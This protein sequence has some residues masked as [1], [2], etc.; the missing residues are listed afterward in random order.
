ML[1]GRL[2]TWL[3][4]R[5]PLQTPT[6]RA[7][8]AS[9]P[10]FACYNGATVTRT[11]D[12]AGRIYEGFCGRPTNGYNGG[13]FGFY[14]VCDGAP[15]AL[16]EFCDARGSIASDPLDGL[17]YW[18]AWKGSERRMNVVPGCVPIGAGDNSNAGSSA[19]WP[20]P[21][22]VGV[23]SPEQRLQLLGGAAPLC[24]ID[25]RGWVYY[26]ERAA[27]RDVAGSAAMRVVQYPPGSVAGTEVPLA[28]YPNDSGSL[29]Q[30]AN[31]LYLIGHHKVG[32]VVYTVSVPVPGGTGPFTINT[33]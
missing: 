12:G 16:Q 24:A 18:T 17:I 33:D 3:A 14:V 30:F 19:P 6:T 11:R 25:S 20:P 7:M 13:L 4:A 29:I 8:T 5:S 28:F 9:I 26:L 31:M 2:T 22:S 27:V 23:L 32:A 10:N 21:P 1:R 15:V